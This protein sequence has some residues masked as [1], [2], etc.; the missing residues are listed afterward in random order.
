MSNDIHTD[1]TIADLKL[2][3]E[4]INACAKRGS[5]QPLEFVPVGTL[6]NKITGIIDLS[7][8]KPTDKQTPPKNISMKRKHKNPSYVEAEQFQ[9]PL[10]N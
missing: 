3:V 5:F 10:E 9:L 1:L 6:I 7:S 2:I 4:I 8:V